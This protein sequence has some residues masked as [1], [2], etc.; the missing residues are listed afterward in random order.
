MGLTEQISPKLDG[1]KSRTRPRKI[2]N[3]FSGSEQ[4][5][6]FFG[7]ISRE[8]GRD[9]NPALT[10]SG[11]RGRPNE[12]NSVPNGFIKILDVIPNASEAK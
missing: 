12:L 1:Y 4:L 10:G 8:I 6:E 9:L 11:S 5:Y 2:Y 3:G 7:K